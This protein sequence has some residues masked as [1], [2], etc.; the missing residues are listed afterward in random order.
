MVTTS[1]ILAINNLNLADEKAMKYSMAAA[2]DS[3]SLL[4]AIFDEDATLK[5]HLAATQIQRK[6]SLIASKSNERC[7]SCSIPFHGIHS[8]KYRC[9]RHAIYSWRGH[10][11]RCYSTR[12]KCAAATWAATNAAA[13]PYRAISIAAAPYPPSTI[14]IRREKTAAT[15]DLKVDAATT[16]HEFTA[17]QDNSETDLA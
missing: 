16:V 9:R 14:P 13:A 6:T 7:R 12:E 3:L 10:R 17:V 8:L 1:T 15:P 11:Q 5:T 2:R 4:I